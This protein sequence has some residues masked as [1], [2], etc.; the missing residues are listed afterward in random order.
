M[1][2]VTPVTPVTPKTPMTRH[3]D[4][5]E[6]IWYSVFGG[7]KMRIYVNVNDDLVGAIDKIGESLS[8]PRSTMVTLA[9]KDFVD[10]YLEKQKKLESK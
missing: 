6:I 5:N 3:V 9:I 1:T 8:L 10:A 4:M 7:E 2:P